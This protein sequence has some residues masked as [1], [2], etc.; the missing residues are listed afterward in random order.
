MSYQAKCIVEPAPLCLSLPFPCLTRISISLN[1]FNF[2]LS[3]QQHFIC[4]NLC[5]CIY[6][7]ICFPFPASDQFLYAHLPATVVTFTLSCLV[8]HTF[9][10]LTLYD[11]STYIHSGFPQRLE[12]LEN[13]NGHGKVMKH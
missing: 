7:I 1:L 6:K 3:C 4:N 11:F 13:G 9:V 10:P 2:S 12:N 8:T 5:P